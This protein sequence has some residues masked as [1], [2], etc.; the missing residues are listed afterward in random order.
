MATRIELPDNQWV[1]ILDPLV[2]S[3]GKRRPAAKMWMKIG[4]HPYSQALA[5]IKRD[6][7][8]A[9][10]AK[11]ETAEAKALSDQQAL[12]VP[13]DYLDLLEQL[14]DE[15]ALCRISAWSFEQAIDLENLLAL[16]S[17]TY[18]I[19]REETAKGSIALLPNFNQQGP[20]SPQ[21]PSTN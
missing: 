3:E 18:K 19:I 14:N 9:S 12:E 1:D 10:P 20:D 6:L 16:P 13:D 15:V 5:R 7:D 4:K 21:S 17:A 11:R 2:V 8:S